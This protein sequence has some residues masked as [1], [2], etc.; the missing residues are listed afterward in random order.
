M[1]YKLAG[2]DVIGCNEIDERTNKNYVR[3]HKPKFNFLCDIRK[4][5]TM[6][7]NRELPEELYNLDVLDGS[8]PCSTFSM[9]GNREADW[10]K[11]KKFREG[12]QK[13]VLDTLFFDFIALAN[14]LRPKVVIAENVK[15]ILL[16]KAM[17][18]TNRIHRELDDAGYYCLHFL[19]NAANM[20]VP[21]RRERCFFVAI[22]KDLARNLDKQEG[23]IFEDSCPKLDLDF[24]E[25]P[26]LFGE[27]A[28]YKGR[29]IVE[30]TKTKLL[31]D[32]I[33]E[34]DTNLSD[35]HLRLFGKRGFYNCAL[36]DDNRVAPT[37]VGSGHGCLIVKSK[38]V[39]VSITENILCGSFPQD[40][41]TDSEQELSY[42][43]GM[44]VPPVMMAQVASRV[45]EQW[46]SKI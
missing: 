24:C 33:Q 25:E 34:G 23:C 3:N 36:Y 13:Q 46:L 45:Y 21:Q 19:L 40:Y 2:F 22:R 5:V 17:E 32:N 7:K 16:G 37:V 39:Y 12:Q 11:E 1:G 31:W 26:I 38:P 14:E 42:L 28:D 27:V 41:E 18:Y 9:S 15:G 30:G 29:P 8:P 43:I 35:A 20:G 10:G 44:S 4:M 6:A